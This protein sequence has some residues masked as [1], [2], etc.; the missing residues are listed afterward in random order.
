VPVPS[1]G[2]DV[3]S[4]EAARL[5]LNERLKKT[6]GFQDSLSKLLMETEMEAGEGFSA[7]ENELGA[8]SDPRR[9]AIGAPRAENPDRERR[10]ARLA[11][12]LDSLKREITGLKAALAENAEH[13]RQKLKGGEK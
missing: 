11:G 7:L 6:E 2:E 8:D 10:K 5:Y 3:F 4:L 9:K 1:G 12:S 13:M